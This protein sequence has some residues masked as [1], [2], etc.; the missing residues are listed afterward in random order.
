MREEPWQLQIFK[1]SLKKK[2]KLKLLEKILVIRASQLALD[3]GCAQGILSY[4]IRQKGGFWVSTDED[5]ANLK[6]TQ[7]LVEEN[8]VQHR[9]GF[10]S[11]KK[12]SFDWLLSLDYLE[13]VENDE[14]CL[15]EIERVLKKD[16]YLILVTPRSGNF[17][18]LHKLRAALGLKL[19]FYGHKREGYS[20][21][22]IEGKLSKAHLRLVKYKTYSRFFSEFF[23]LILNFLYI[24]F[25]SARTQAKLRDGH[26]RPSTSAEFIAQK[27]SF[28][29]YSFIYPLVWVFS[30]LDTLLFF[31][32]GYSLIVL[33]QKTS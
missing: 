15:E 5:Y 31:Q 7:S 8:L 30:R 1:K 20:L 28:K 12:Q 17:F 6:T 25:F 14:Q 4:F 13:H 11:F 29:L 2:E 9:S 10:F 26:I 19:E 22:E 33:A 24:K 21:K 16:G 32:K 27:K 23:E 18:I 3:L